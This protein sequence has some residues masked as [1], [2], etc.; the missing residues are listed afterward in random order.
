MAGASRWAGTV[1]GG[2]HI[3]HEFLPALNLSDRSGAC[4]CKRIDAM[5]CCRMATSFGKS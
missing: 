3:G 4:A 1:S 2:L 5:S